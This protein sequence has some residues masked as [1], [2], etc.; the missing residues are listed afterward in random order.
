MRVGGD[1]RFRFCRI[2]LGYRIGHGWEG[3]GRGREGFRE[4]HRRHGCTKWVCGVGGCDRGV[5]L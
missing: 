3:M 4:V 1:R 2:G 5:C